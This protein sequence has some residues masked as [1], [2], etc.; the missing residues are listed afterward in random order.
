MKNKIITVNDAKKELQR[1]TQEIK[2]INKDFDIPKRAHDISKFKTLLRKFN[3][4]FYV[5]SIKINGRYREPI[6]SRYF[7]LLKNK[8]WLMGFISA[9]L[10]IGKKFA[11]CEVQE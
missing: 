1:V 4:S 11:K 10:N 5:K 9:R 2:Q 7:H 6:E 8:Y 3:K